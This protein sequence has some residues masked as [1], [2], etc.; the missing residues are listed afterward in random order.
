MTFIRRHDVLVE[1]STAGGATAFS[2]AYLNGLLYAIEFD[3]STDSPWSSAADFT[4]TKE[5]GPDVLHVDLGS[6][7]GQIFFPRRVANTT[8]SGSLDP[9]G[10]TSGR[11]GVMLPFANERAQIVVSSGGATTS[12]TVRLYMA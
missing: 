10:N 1:M 8:S 5:N 7:T 9:A 12:G 6:G 2:S 4:I 11:E 3:P